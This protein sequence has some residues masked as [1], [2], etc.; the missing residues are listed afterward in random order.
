MREVSRNFAIRRVARRAARKAVTWL[1]AHREGFRISLDSTEGVPWR[2][3]QI[4]E[5]MFTLTVLKRHDS[6]PRALDG[7]TRFALEEAATFD[8]HELAAY[9]PSA[10]TPIAILADFYALENQAVPFD[11]EYFDLLRQVDYFEGMDRL[12]FRDMDVAYCFSR[13]GVPNQQSKINLWFTGTAFGRRQRLARYTLDDLYSLT[14]AIFY[15]TDVGLEPI[16][17][18]AVTLRR[19]HYELVA[20]TA[21]MMR[22]DNVDVLAEFLLCWVC[23]GLTPTGP[24]AIIFRAGMERIFAAISDEGAVAPTNR[25][26]QR[27][28]SGEATFEELYHTTLVAVMLFSLV[29]GR[30]I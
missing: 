26:K 6:R 29:A 27:A 24:R 19:L 4:G 21:I 17:L 15:L 1:E 10:A 11:M 2:V 14:H 28:D 5:L 23:C 8:W 16:T 7:L 12:P 9:D 3:K 18:D 22:A 25:I 13:I 30:K 20:L